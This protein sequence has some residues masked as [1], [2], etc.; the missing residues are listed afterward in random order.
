M[1]LD[2][3]CILYLIITYNFVPYKFISLYK[4]GFIWMV[5]P[6]AIC[7]ALYAKVGPGKNVGSDLENLPHFFGPHEKSTPGEVE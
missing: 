2:M 1:Y 3:Y 4:I 6:T 7:L 5:T